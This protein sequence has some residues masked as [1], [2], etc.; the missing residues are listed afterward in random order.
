[1]ALPFASALVA[2]L[3]AV[4][5]AQDPASHDDRWTLCDPGFPVQVR[6][7]P[8]EDPLWLAAANRSAEVLHVSSVVL[9]VELD[10][11]AHVRTEDVTVFLALFDAET[12]SSS[13]V[14]HADA[15]LAGA[16]KYRV[17]VGTEKAG[18]PIVLRVYVEATTPIGGEKRRAFYARTLDISPSDA[19]YL[20]CEARDA[21][22]DERPRTALYPPATIPPELCRGFT[23]DGRVPVRKWYIDD[24]T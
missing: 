18:K 13:P 24:Q 6:V 12:G 5:S 3:L 14:V 23:M 4:A 21:D 11:P 22:S 19:V 7:A 17:A 2:A 9:D 15:Q 20:E 1:M 16:P 10:L 8:F